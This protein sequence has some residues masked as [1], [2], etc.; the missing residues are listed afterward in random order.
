MFS[1]IVLK[2]AEYLY[3]KRKQKHLILLHGVFSREKQETSR[4]PNYLTLCY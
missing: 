4:S 1:G 3:E 2:I